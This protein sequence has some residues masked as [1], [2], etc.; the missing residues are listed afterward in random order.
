MQNTLSQ[1]RLQNLQ[2]GRT[3][4]TRQKGGSSVDVQM[5]DPFLQIIMNMIAQ[6]QDSQLN[7][8]AD[9]LPTTAQTVDGL[10]TI[11]QAA[12]LIQGSLFNLAQDG[13]LN[14]MNGLMSG[15]EQLVIGADAGNNTIEGAQIA[16]SAGTQSTLEALIK[17][18]Q[19]NQAALN[20]GLQVPEKTQEA[21]IQIAAPFLDTPATKPSKNIREMFAQMTGL[22][23]G[24]GLPV[25]SACESEGLQS[26]QNEFGGAVEK[27]KELLSQ[28]TKRDD[29]KELDVDSL[30]GVV[31]QTKVTTPFELRFKSVSQAAETPIADQI[32]QGI[33]ENLV[34]GKGEFT[35]KLKPENLGEITIKLIEDA[36]KT[37][38]SITTASAQ[39]AKLINNEIN[40]LKQAVAPMHVEVNEAVSQSQQSHAGTMQQFDMAGQQFAQQQFAQQQ[41]AQWQSQH[42]LSGRMPLTDDDQYADDAVAAN[43]S[44]LHAIMSTRIDAYI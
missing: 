43:A 18:L 36:G 17:G 1:V 20:S 7:Q 6:N 44:Q 23:V 13:Q 28:M 31:S 21:A 22:S 30:Q 15:L 41:F 37:T 2:E 26:G 25:L 16:S 4:A 39:T 10:P 9:G 24:E 40:A 27:A 14:S 3:Q 8:T 5:A 11:A 33:K 34:N 35:M 42:T 12:D 29:Q 32:S 19:A 38:L